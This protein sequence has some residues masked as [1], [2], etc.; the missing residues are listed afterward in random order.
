MLAGKLKDQRASK[1][2]RKLVFGEETLKEVQT[3][4][5]A[6]R[7]IKRKAPSALIKWMR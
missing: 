7:D 4:I 2:G 5:R 1:S 3:V 6:R